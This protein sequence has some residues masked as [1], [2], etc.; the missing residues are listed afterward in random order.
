MSWAAAVA[1]PAGAAVV[2]EGE[3]LQ[4][5]AVTAAV[6]PAART[7]IKSRFRTRIVISFCDVTVAYQG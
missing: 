6:A 2:L 5:A 4:P 1:G 3:L 7:I